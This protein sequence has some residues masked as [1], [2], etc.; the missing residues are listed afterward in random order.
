[1]RTKTHGGQTVPGDGRIRARR[2]TTCHGVATRQIV[3]AVRAALG[4]TP[5]S[6]LAVVVVDDAQIM[7]LHEQFMGDST[8]TDVLTFDLRDDLV[9]GPIEAEIVLSAE[10]AERQAREFHT[11]PGQELLRYAIHGTLHLVGFDDH[12]PSERRRAWERLWRGRQQEPALT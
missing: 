1:M 2:L 8:P 4:D 11:E 9:E 7:R 5:C 10:T 12:T 6:S 3:Q